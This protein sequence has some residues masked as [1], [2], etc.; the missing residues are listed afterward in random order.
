MIE[1][2]NR[3]SIERDH[4]AVL[5]RL[6]AQAQVTCQSTELA[7]MAEIVAPAFQAAEAALQSE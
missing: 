3:V 2:A 4:L 1:T 6:A 5:Y 7:Q